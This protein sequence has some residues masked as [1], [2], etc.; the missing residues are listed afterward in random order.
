MTRSAAQAAFDDNGIEFRL[1]HFIDLESENG[2]KLV[3]SVVRSVD[4]RKATKCLETDTAAGQLRLLS[5]ACKWNAEYAEIV[6]N[7][8]RLTSITSSVHFL[9]APFFQ[10]PHLKG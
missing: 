5:L 9:F 7:F 6:F 3:S 8:D 2:I 1:R 4:V 10:S